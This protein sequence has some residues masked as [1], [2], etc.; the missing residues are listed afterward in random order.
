M[1][2]L[3]HLFG[4]QKRKSK[5]LA[6]DEIRREARMASF[7][8]HIANYANRRALAIQFNYANVDKLLS[9]PA[10]LDSVMKQVEDSISPEIVHIRDDEK[11]DED[12][13]HDLVDIMPKDE[14]YDLTVLVAKSEKKQ[15]Q[16]IAMFKELLKILKAELHL[17]KMIRNHPENTK[18]LLLRLFELIM[19]H[20]VKIYVLF[21][22]GS[23]MEENLFQHKTVLSIARAIFLGEKIEERAKTDAERFAEKMIFKITQKM[24]LSGD[25]TPRRYRGLAEK[26]FYELAAMAGAPLKRE[27]DLTLV[28]KK[29]ESFMADDN[30]MFGIVKKLRPRYSDDKARLMVSV[31]RAAYDMGHLRDLKS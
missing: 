26:V 2:W 10:A 6:S 15:E 23:L 20:E 27:E 19:N 3:N 14:L 1:A 29:M 30:L 21:Q 16:M 8:Q 31:F 7:N 4:G 13:L 25:E 9:N 5:R 11:S 12:V 22:K 24:K 17:V 28:I 18:E